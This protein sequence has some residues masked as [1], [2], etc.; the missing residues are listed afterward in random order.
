MD[1]IIKLPVLIILALIVLSLFRGMYYLSK[2]DGEKNKSRVVKALT[3]R[4]VLSFV[5]FTLLA[6]GYLTGLIEPFGS[7]PHSQ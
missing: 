6:V 7:V 3:V 1:I 2:D 4:I 5:L